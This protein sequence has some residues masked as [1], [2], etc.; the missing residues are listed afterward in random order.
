MGKFK[1]PAPPAPSTPQVNSGKVV[2]RVKGVSNSSGQLSLVAA[3]DDLCRD[4]LVL[5]GDVPETFV[6]T[7]AKGPASEWRRRWR[8]A[9][10]E[11]LRLST[12]LRERDKELAGKDCQIKQ[13]RKFVEEEQRTRMRAEAERDGLA[14]QIRATVDVLLKDGAS[15]IKNDDTLERIRTLDRTVRNG[16]AYSGSAFRSSDAADHLAHLKQDGNKIFAKNSLCIPNR[17]ICA[18]FGRRI[19][20]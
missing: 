18:I 13:A 16:F 7:F 12:L 19:W 1:A 11:R 6:L 8:L 10:T 4:S 5:R 20:S 15:S 14:S 2:K 9:E 3:F 17:I